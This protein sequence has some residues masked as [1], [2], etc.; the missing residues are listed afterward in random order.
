MTC[1]KVK[2]TASITTNTIFA[3]LLISTLVVLGPLV[4]RSIGSDDGSPESEATIRFVRALR[5]VQ[6]KYKALFVALQL[7]S[8]LLFTAPVELPPVTIAFLDYFQMLSAVIPGS[9]FSNRRFSLYTNLLVW[10]IAPFAL[11]AF[12]V[13]INM[14]VNLVC[15]SIASL[16]AVKR[17]EGHRQRPFVNL[18]Y[19]N[20]SSVKAL[21]LRTRHIS[22]DDSRLIFSR[23]IG[24]SQV[25]L[26]VLVIV[27]FLSTSVSPKI[28][29]RF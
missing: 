1:T 13:F 21:V 4:F 16:S 15:S 7:W 14:I 6:T 12:S 5:K 9:C 2:S 11:V 24:D 23:R 18:V 8:V 27:A 17:I 26:S 28:A 10:T 22:R 20:I 25:A 29:C 3:I 19:H